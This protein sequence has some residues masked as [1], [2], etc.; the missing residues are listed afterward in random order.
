MPSS[1]LSAPMTPVPCDPRCSESGSGPVPWGRVLAVVALALAASTALSTPFAIG[2][3]PAEAVGAIV[4]LAQLTP[5][6]AVI[7]MRPR[8]ADGAL[9]PVRRA[10]A[11]AVP[12][13]RALGLGLL[14]AVVAFAAVPLVRTAIAV[15]TGSAA[16]APADG[17]LLVA[18][19]VPA[20]LV[21]QT[22]FAIGEETAW[23][24]ALHTALA[25]LGFWRSTLLIGGLW[26]LWHAPIVVALGFSAREAAA[27][28]LLI[29][30]VAPLLGALRELGM[31]VWP[32]VLGHGL[33]NS[34]R[35]GIDQNLLGPIA[36]RETAGFWIVEASG[37]ILWLLAAAVVLRIARR[38][39]A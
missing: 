33:L 16:F 15:A 4:P 25:P 22:L 26:M 6:L 1:S 29:L 38:R 7:L 11:L 8:G 23:R 28:L 39:Q 36:E 21:L 17:L 20:V 9:V 32:A 5:M 37:W 12:S 18:A 2:L 34:L 31:S 35:V 27:Y 10:L 13:R 30:A 24:G 19:A 14:A 3:L